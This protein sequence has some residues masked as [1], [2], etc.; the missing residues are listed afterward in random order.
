[1]NDKVELTAQKILEK[2]FTKDVKGYSSDE[3]DSFL[4]QIIR[5]YVSFSSYQKSSSAYVEELETNLKSLQGQF[6]DLADEKQALWNQKKQ[7]EI[8][9]AALHNKLDGIKPGDNPTVENMAY[10]QRIRKLEDF[11]YS[12]GYSPNDLKRKK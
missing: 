5:D 6:K 11:L 12:E 9:N 7:L 10:I 8:D 2:K 4:D 1:M 3:V